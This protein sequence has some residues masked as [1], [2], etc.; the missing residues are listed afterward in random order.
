MAVWT[1]ASASL[2]IGGSPNA[3]RVRLRAAVIG[4]SCTSPLSDI[5]DTDSAAVSDKAVLQALVSGRVRV[6]SGLRVE[7]P[8]DSLACIMA[9]QVSATLVVPAAHAMLLIASIPHTSPRSPSFS[10]LMTKYAVPLKT[11]LQNVLLIL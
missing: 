11:R 6:T 10:A 1:A 2:V 5:M 7:E 8:A 4:S 3:V 9:A